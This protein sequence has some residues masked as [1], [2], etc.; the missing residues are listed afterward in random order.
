MNKIVWFRYDLRLEDNEAFIE[1]SKNSNLLPIFIYDKN[2]F[3]LDTTSSFHLKFLNQS[4]EELSKLLK[5]NFNANLNIY[6]G[7]SLQILSNLIDKFKIS[8]I[9]SNRVVNNNFITNLDLRC[10]KMFKEKNTNWLRFNQFGIQLNHRVRKDW[11]KNWN[12]FIKK[13]NSREKSF[14]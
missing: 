14:M 3:L 5:K 6:Y 12:I 13:K 8:E 1:A 4:I 9:Y 2:Y 11:S 10:E 7:D